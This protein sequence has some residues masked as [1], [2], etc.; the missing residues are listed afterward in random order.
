MKPRARFSVFNGNRF[1]GDID[2]IGRPAKQSKN[3]GWSALIGAVLSG[4]VVLLCVYL[5]ISLIF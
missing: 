5:L 4:L 1:M 3:G 2:L